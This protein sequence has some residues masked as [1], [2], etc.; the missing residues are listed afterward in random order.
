MDG[1]LIIATF[2]TVFVAEMLGDKTLLTI[3]ALATRFRPAPVFAGIVIAFMGKVL[4]A[5]LLGRAI[6][7]LPANAVAATSA[8]TFLGTALVIWLNRHEKA[9]IEVAPATFWPRAA[10]TAFAAIFF[11]EWADAG[12]L[13]TAM[14]AAR[15]HAP[16]MVWIGATLALST[17][18]VLALVFGVGL[19]RRVPRTALRFAA[20][21]ACLVMSIHAAMSIRI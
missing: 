10:V 11:S 1:Y 6:A 20:L 4:A 12:Q 5:V 14:L 21:T 7:E 2:G 15:S 8:A 13:T 19:S 17:K 16:L 9:Q 18:G 3:S